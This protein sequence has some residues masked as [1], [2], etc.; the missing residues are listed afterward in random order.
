MEALQKVVPPTDFF[1]SGFKY[2]SIYF[3]DLVTTLSSHRA[4]Q[5]GLQPSH[6]IVPDGLT[7]VKL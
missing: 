2:L 7:A 3:L 6:S 4:S 5:H 1:Y